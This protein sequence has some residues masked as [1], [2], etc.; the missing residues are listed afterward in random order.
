MRKGIGPQGLGAP[1]S[2]A[3]QA[4]APQGERDLGEGGLK[5]ETLGR[6][7]KI[8]DEV[9]KY[10]DAGKGYESV[11]T[12]MPGVDRR[13]ADDEGY[14]D[15]ARARAGN[16]YYKQPGNYEAEQNRRMTTRVGIKLG[17]EAYKAKNK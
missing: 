7:E 1:K 2:P 4:K 14:I 9:K 3:K 16:S 6:A 15:R 11:S 5:G 12:G 10:Q 8:V 13:L 17:H